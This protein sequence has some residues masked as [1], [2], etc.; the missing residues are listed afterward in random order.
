MSNTI[1]NNTPT[2][3][4]GQPS[5]EARAF[6]VAFIPP[7]SQNLTTAWSLQASAAIAALIDFRSS[8][9][10]WQAAGQVS[11]AD[12]VTQVQRLEEAGLAGYV[13]EL[14]ATAVREVAR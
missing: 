8:V 3:P 9:H 11:D 5:L 1:Q 4:N 6:S 12:F 13:D 10:R 7:R 14:M 2:A